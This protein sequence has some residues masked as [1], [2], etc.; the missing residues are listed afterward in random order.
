MRSNVLCSDARSVHKCRLRALCSNACSMQCCKAA[1][2]LRLYYTL[3][4]SCNQGRIKSWE[5]SRCVLGGACDKDSPAKVHVTRQGRMAV[6]ANLGSSSWSLSDL[7]PKSIPADCTLSKKT[8]GVLEPWATAIQTPMHQ[9]SHSFDVRFDWLTRSACLGHYQGYRRG[10][11]AWYAVQPDLCC[12]SEG[13]QWMGMA[14][15][16][17]CVSCPQ[18][19][20]D[21]PC[22]GCQHSCPCTASIHR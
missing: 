5:P 17:V 22:S 15:P 9:C 16:V 7:Q 4:G 12:G 11:G 14:Y 20:V 10:V 19:Q 6:S 18:S 13:W 21:L 2:P 8:D 1:A 3:G